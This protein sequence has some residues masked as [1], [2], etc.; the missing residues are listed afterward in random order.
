M[1]NEKFVSY[2][3]VAQLRQIPTHEYSTT[4]QYES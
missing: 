3:V 2:D 4:D 1:A